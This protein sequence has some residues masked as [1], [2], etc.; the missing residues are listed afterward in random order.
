ML[1]ALKRPTT[2]ATPTL[3]VNHPAH[4]VLGTHRCRRALNKMTDTGKHVYSIPMLPIM[5]MCITPHTQLLRWRLPWLLLRH[6]PQ[7]QQCCQQHRPVPGTPA[8]SNQA[9]RGMK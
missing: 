4:R 9:K 5:F 2:V 1:W 7:Q 6:E 8:G 3:D